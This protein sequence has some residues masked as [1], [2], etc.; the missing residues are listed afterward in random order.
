MK[1][2]DYQP[3]GVQAPRAA[4]DGFPNKPF[5]AQIYSSKG[6]GKTNTLVNIIDHYDKHK[7]FQKVVLFSPTQGH[8]PKY[9]YL[10]DGSYELEVYGNYTD[11]IFRGVLESIKR[12]LYEW[13]EYNR[14]KKLYE[15]AQRVT[16]PDKLTDEEL[17]DLYMLDFQMPECRFDREP[18]TLIVFD[19]QVGN[20][21]LYNSTK[22]LASQFFIL[23][24]HLRCSC[25]F[26][27]QIYKNAMPKGIRSNLDWIILGAS[28]SD[29]TMED[30]ATELD[31]YASKQEIKRMWIEATAE[32]YS[33]FCIN[34]MMPAYRFTRNFDEPLL[35]AK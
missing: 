18:Y 12:D 33:Y 9:E 6:T 1:L 20:K 32:P 5:L 8:D 22:S 23:H 3:K 10:R 29:D 7:F 35:P 2:K 14:L 15:K 4:P 25:V 30:V 17:L 34:L 28:K 26:V 27:V 21:E 19:D 24:R 16:S 11:E 13:E 31:A